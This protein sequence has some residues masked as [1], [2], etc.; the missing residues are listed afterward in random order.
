MIK[1]LAIFLGGG[2][3]ACS[4][5]LTCNKISQ[6]QLGFPYGVLFVNTLGSLILGI[7]TG[8]LIDKIELSENTKALIITGFCGAYTTFSAFSLDVWSI[9]SQGD[10]LKCAI[11]IASNVILSI[12]ALFIGVFLAKQF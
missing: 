2:L 9:F 11:Y 8:L 6:L 3:G 4:R 10:Y 1:L 7:V 5:F 12:S